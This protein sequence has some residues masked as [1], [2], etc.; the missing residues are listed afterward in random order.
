MQRRE[1]ITFLDCAV[2][3][4][5]LTVRAQQPQRM[6]RIGVLI[7]HVKNDSESPLLVQSRHTKMLAETGVLR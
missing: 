2:A 6:Q 7:A 4:W 5:P 1:L 3:V